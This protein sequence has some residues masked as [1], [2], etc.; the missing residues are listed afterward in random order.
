MD[1]EA[2]FVSFLPQCPFTVSLRL[3]LISTLS[4]S[5]VKSKL[6][7]S[8]TREWSEMS[9]S[10]KS[11][12][13]TRR[14]LKIFALANENQN[15]QDK[16]LTQTPQGIQASSRAL[17]I[18]GILNP[19]SYSRHSRHL[20]QS[21]RFKYRICHCYHLLTTSKPDRQTTFAISYSGMAFTFSFS[22]AFPSSVH[23]TPHFFALLFLLLAA[24]RF[25]DLD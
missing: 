13:E 7:A 20:Q 1:S 19:L 15:S 24:G 23:I 14:K 16:S 21:H 18:A 9:N 11:R 22:F 10:M 6:R 5:R 12:L 3:P 25:R 2:R 17:P 8:K 4:I